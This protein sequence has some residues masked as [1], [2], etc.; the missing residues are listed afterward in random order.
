MYYAFLLKP[1]NDILAILVGVTTIVCEWIMKVDVMTSLWLA[2]GV[3]QYW[4]SA[5]VSV[6]CCCGSNAG[7]QWTAEVLRRPHGQGVSTD[8]VIVQHY[9]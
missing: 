5:G 7:K 6:P 9:R 1:L 4:V 2:G 8:P 3:E